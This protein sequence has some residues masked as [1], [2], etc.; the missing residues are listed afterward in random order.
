MTGLLT[1]D[2][3]ETVKKGEV[4]R[5][6]VRQVTDAAAKPVQ[7]PPEVVIRKGAR[8]SRTSA[9]AVAGIQVAAGA[10]PILRWRR[11]VG[12]YQITIPVRTKEV[13]LPAETRLLSVLRWNLGRMSTDERWYQV[14][15]RYV[16]LIGDRVGALGGDPDTVEGSPRA[17]P[18]AEERPTTSPVAVTAIASAIPRTAGPTC[19]YDGKVSGVV[20]DCFGDFEGFILDDC[21]REI[22]FVVREHEMET[23]VRF[24][25]RERVAISVVVRVA[26]RR[27]P[28]SIILRRAP[29]LVGAS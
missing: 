17:S 9:A 24:A 2:L 8:A 19:T 14:F 27:R 29:E 11:I 15:S 21:G 23:L 4:Y 3:P 16:G 6:V 26:D 20:Y 7:P 10:R 12:S 1:V 13:M 22:R 28:V 18:A 5:I 25:W